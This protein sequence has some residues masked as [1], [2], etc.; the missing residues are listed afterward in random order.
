MIKKYIK[1]YLKS[2][3]LV[4][5]RV[6]AS[7]K[8][9]R[10]ENIV[11]LLSFPSTSEYIIDELSIKYKDRLIIC[12]TK[13][14]KSLAETYK[15]RKIKVFSINSFIDLYTN[16]IPALASTK[17]ILCDNY[18]AILAG[19]KFD[20]DV[21][22]VQLWHANGAVKKFGAEA[23]YAKQAMKT[24]QRRYQ[25]VYDQY[26]HIVV[27]SKKMAEIFCKSY[28]NEYK[29][30]P[31]GYPLTDVY[32]QNNSNRIS[33]YK[34]FD[35]DT[36][37]KIALYAPTYRENKNG[38]QMNLKEL[39]HRFPKDWQLVVRPHPHDNSLKQQLVELQEIVHMPEEVA[40]T[41]LFNQVDCIITD[42]S[43][44]P[45]EYTLSRKQGKIIY[46]C[47]DL[48][49][50]DSTVGIQEDF[51]KWSAP[52]RVTTITDLISLLTE[53]EQ[54]DFKAFNDCWNTFAKGNSVNQLIEWIDKHYEN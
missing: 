39:S 18:F 38:K 23:L 53:K 45:F 9:K 47:Y 7:L 22:V 5:I 26:T 34:M 44:I 54:I 16:I 33:F 19:F 11:F 4:P 52:D 42:Y 28:L 31:F 36:R 35:I 1:A 17:V 15:K 29:V 40:I 50:Y 41:N 6:L 3:Y 13:E 10:N 2:G 21:N 14:A 37:K 27:S 8:R 24:D 25:K 30:L 51:I 20:K 32:F 49:E 46:Y 12:Y 43:S 48:Q